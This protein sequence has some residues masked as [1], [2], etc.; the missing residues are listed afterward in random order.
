M[1][2][3]RLTA[4]NEA[5]ERIT[6]LEAA[7]QVFRNPLGQASPLCG[8]LFDRAQVLRDKARNAS[9]TP[10][11]SNCC[12]RLAVRTG[13]SAWSSLCT[14]LGK[15]LP[16]YRKLRETMKKESFCVGSGIDTTTINSQVKQYADFC[17]ERRY[18]G[19][20]FLSFDATSIFPSLDIDPETRCLKGHPFI[21]PIRVMGFE[22]YQRL[23]KDCPRAKHLY[24]FCVTS[25]TDGNVPPTI[26][27]A[28]PSDD[29]F[30]AEWLTR[31]VD[32]IVNAFQQN[33]LVV[34]GFSADGA[35]KQLSAMMMISDMPKYASMDF[36]GFVAFLSSEAG[37]QWMK[38]RPMMI[39]DPLHGL[40]KVSLGKRFDGEHLCSRS[41]LF[42]SCHRWCIESRES[43]LMLAVSL[44]VRRPYSKLLISIY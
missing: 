42:L 19:P 40:M 7:I 37:R 28:F 26:L 36:R 15:L 5:K 23:L 21:K 24:I 16:T 18:E 10:Q 25:I 39:Q 1:A 34:D 13:K 31:K 6:K 30:K 32:E 22:H 17:K 44:F 14:A 12:A 11:M 2:Q 9:Y 3:T 27:L 29:C 35:S 4:L 8:E 20:F 38:G 41:S 33:D 43:C